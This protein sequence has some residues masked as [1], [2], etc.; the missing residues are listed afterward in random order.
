MPNIVPVLINNINRAMEVTSSVLR[1][2]ADDTKE[3]RVVEKEEQRE[4]L[5]ST[6]NKLVDCGGGGPSEHE[7][8]HV[9]RQGCNQ[10]QCHPWAAIKS[11]HP[12][13]R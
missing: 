5:Q 3:G 11:S 2:F 6:I 7:A 4:E 13:M 1:K 8:N 12:D 9:V 10:G